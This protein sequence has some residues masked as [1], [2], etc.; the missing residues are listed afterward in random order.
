MTGPP[1][2]YVPKNVVYPP[3]WEPKIVT[4]PPSPPPR[5]RNIFWEKRVSPSRKEE[6]EDSNT[7]YS[8]RLIAQQ[9]FTC[10]KTTIETLE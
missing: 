8:L 3:L 7:M 5:T 6:G 10:P 1:E 2:K 9:A 4:P